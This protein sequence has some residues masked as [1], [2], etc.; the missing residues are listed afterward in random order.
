MNLIQGMMPPNGFHF[1]EGK[2]ILRAGSL[3]EL[4]SVVEAYR[5]ENDIPYK[6]VEPEIH[7]YFCS[8]WPNFC[9]FYDNEQA[10]Q[11]P[12]VSPVAKP[13]LLNDLQA[14]SS[15]IINQ[16]NEPLGVDAGVA[17]ARADICKRCDHNVKWKSGCGSCINAV[18]RTTAAIRSARDTTTSKTLGA[19]N[20]MRHCNRTAVW[21]DKTAFLNP[22]SP[23]P[24]ACWLNQ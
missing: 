3:Q 12:F 20:V 24:K 7:E 2:V 22:A 11:Q 8:R 18:E 4:V 5:A 15:S 17:E 6:D 21:L 1:P 16:Q 10:L 13:T 9:H 23:L 19:C 14:W